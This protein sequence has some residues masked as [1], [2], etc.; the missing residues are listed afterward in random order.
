MVIEIGIRCLK[1]K[2]HKILYNYLKVQQS[3]YFLSQ[4]H[5]LIYQLF[6]QKVQQTLFFENRGLY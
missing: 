1:L 4:V 6:K 5:R 3:H 2:D